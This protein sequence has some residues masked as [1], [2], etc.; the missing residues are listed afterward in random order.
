MGRRGRRGLSGSTPPKVSISRELIGQ[1]IGEAPNAVLTAAQVWI[2]LVFVSP[3]HDA[4]WPAATSTTAVT[5]IPR[6]R[7]HRGEQHIDMKT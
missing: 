1:E 2:K 6:V 4:G 7:L 3:K 5:T